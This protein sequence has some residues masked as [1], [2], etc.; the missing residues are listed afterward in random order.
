[1][2]LA[3]TL[4]PRLSEWRPAGD[5]RHSWAEAFPAHGW[6]VRLAA[7]K[8]DSVGC[9]VWELTLVRTA[10]PPVST[11]CE[12]LLPPLPPLAP[13]TLAGRGVWSRRKLVSAWLAGA[14][15][16]RQSASRATRPARW[17]RRCNGTTGVLGR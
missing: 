5:G 11:P 9:L 4:Q 6:S 8:A 10:E 14:A 3:E 1:M 2:T 16:R 15:T 17:R 13:V 12:T 7:D